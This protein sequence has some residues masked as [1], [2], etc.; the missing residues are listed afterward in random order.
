[1]Q[2]TVLN[3][4]LQNIQVVSYEFIKADDVFSDPDLGIPIN[5]AIP[6]PS[7]Q[8]SGYEMVEET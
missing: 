7:R 2:T 8:A 5:I 3:S 1:M 6:L 4:G